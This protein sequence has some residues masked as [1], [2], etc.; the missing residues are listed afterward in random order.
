LKSRWR[1]CRRAAW[2]TIVGGAKSARL[3]RTSAPAAWRD[4]FRSPIVSVTIRMRSAGSSHQTG[5]GANIAE[6]RLP[7]APCSS[8]ART[9]IGT[10][11]RSSSPL[12][13]CPRPRM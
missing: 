7:S 13:E 12:V 5:R 11:A 3:V 2:P 4:F 9:L 1:D 6:T 10:I 8:S